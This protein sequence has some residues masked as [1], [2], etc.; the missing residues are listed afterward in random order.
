MDVVLPTPGK[1]VLAVSGGVDSMVLLDMLR[2]QPGLILTVAHLDHGIRGDSAEDRQLVQQAAR[3]HGL[4]FVYHEEKLGA[5]ASEAAAR[6]ARYAFLRRVQRASG[7]RAII[8]AHHQDDVLETAILNLMRGS[9][10]KGLTSLGS[11]HDIERPLLHIP[12]KDL[13]AYAR[14]QGLV[15]REDSTN[16]NLEYQRNYV[17][18][19]LLPRFDE[20]ART[21]LLELI[22]DL[23]TINYE[24][25]A[26]LAT[27]LHLQT[28]GG[29]LD[30]QWFNQ[31]PHGV[32]RETMAA[33]LRAHAA[34]GFD[35]RLL[36]RLVVAAK[37]A[38]P[39]KVFDVFQ[40][41]KL[42]IESQYLALQVPER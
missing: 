3:R 4:P 37:V 6:T 20:A 24:L 13:I 5:G 29:T 22:S 41:V 1:Y 15:W 28:I 18:Q 31:L 30:R 36:E 12:K 19:R 21:Q 9:G 27:Q 23:R 25:D 38:A 40:G 16:H 26:L 35:S 11:R 8:T 34:G 39:G 10:R 32:A 17:R 42:H 14:D 7:A 2:H 33:W